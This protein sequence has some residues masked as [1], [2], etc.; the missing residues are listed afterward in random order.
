MADPSDCSETVN[1]QFDAVQANWD[2]PYHAHASLSLPVDAEELLFSAE[3]PLAHGVFEVSQS[4]H[5]GK[6]VLIDIDV[7]YRLEA[8]LG[9]ATVCHLNPS[10]N[11]HGLGIFTERWQHPEFKKQLRFHV[12][13]L[14]PATE[15]GAPRTI[16]AFNT[17][18]PQFTHHLH[19]LADTVVFESIDLSATNAGIRADSLNAIFG[20]LRSSNGKIE[21]T[22]NTTSSLELFTSNAPVHITANLLNKDID[23]TTVLTVE[24][25]NADIHANVGLFAD[26]VDGAYRVNARTDNA[27]A[28]V[29]ITSAPA[30]SL[31]N[32]SAVSSNAPVVFGAHPAF[33][34]TF[35][36]HS[37]WF[38]PP[39]VEDRQN[40]EDPLRR[41][42]RRNVQ[43]RN[44]NRGAIRGE[45]GWEPKHENA[46]SG[47]IGLETS[48]AHVTLIF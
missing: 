32:A 40:A 45:V 31:L 5:T 34:G 39:K 38:T 14:L 10:D 3:G 20:R 33:E 23:T 37:T 46:K 24:T 25:S 4:H 43:V 1:W 30:N 11:R 27:P 42:R 41:G 47:H 35:E 6:D 12:H 44:V 19:E 29:S 17:H 48:N 2:W 18:L 9:S 13:V 7:A 15:H 16:N 36:L 26:S 21:G 8:A 22:Y 28:K